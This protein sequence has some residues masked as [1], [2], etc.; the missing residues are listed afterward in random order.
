MGGWTQG[1]G[2]LQVPLIQK[3]HT[4]VYIDNSNKLVSFALF[5][6]SP[7]HVQSP[8]T[9]LEH[10]T[11][12]SPQPQASQA[13]A[14]ASST[15]TKIHTESLY[16]VNFPFQSSLLT[17]QTQSPSATIFHLTS[18]P[19]LH[20]HLNPPP[21]FPKLDT[22]MKYKEEPSGLGSRDE[23]APFFDLKRRKEKE[24]RHTRR[25]T[26]SHTH[27]CR[28]YQTKPEEKEEQKQKNPGHQTPPPRPRRNSNG[29]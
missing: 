29:A 26:H 8:S 4:C 18:N 12:P 19:P 16:S 9:P 6:S 15:S 27:T 22:Y 3:P 17:P 10:T 25:E 2:Y 14:Q 5:P 20:H 11:L 24:K 21:P 28:G 1:R 23:I 13:Q 7:I